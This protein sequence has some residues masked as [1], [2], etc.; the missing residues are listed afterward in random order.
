V[1]VHVDDQGRLYVLEFSSAAGGPAPG[2]GRILRI[3]GKLV[4]EIVSGLSVP[5][6]MTFDSHGDIYVSDL[7]AAPPGAGRIL[8]F[9][10]PISGTV[11]TTINV[12]NPAPLKY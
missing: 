6:A 2:N 1:D 12:R 10:N 9:D 7:G 8:R 3:T 11:I 5:T 4:E